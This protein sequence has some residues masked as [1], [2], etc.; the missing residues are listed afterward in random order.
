VR[1]ARRQLAVLARQ[2]Q[3]P[4]KR[5]RPARERRSA[6]LEGQRNRHRRSDPDAERLDGVELQ[7][8]EV[9]EAVEQHRCPAPQRRGCPYGI[10][11][12][13]RALLGIGAPDPCQLLQVLVVEEGQRPG[14]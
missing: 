12:S 3:Q 5:R 2:R 6:P 14:P 9:V 4:L 8:G 11:G 1:V 10:Q 7:P 13:D